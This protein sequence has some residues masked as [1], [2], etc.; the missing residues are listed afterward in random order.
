[1]I[2]SA[3]LI[4]KSRVSVFSVFIVMTTRYTFYNNDVLLVPLNARAFQIENQLSNHNSRNMLN[5]NR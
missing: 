3:S 1:M 2:E 4:I 5:R